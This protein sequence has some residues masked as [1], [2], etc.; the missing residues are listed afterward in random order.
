[1]TKP[2]IQTLLILVDGAFPNNGELPLVLFQQAFDPTTKNL[3][4]TIEKTFHGN[5]WQNSWRNGIFTFH[6]YHSTAH[7]VLGIYSGRVKAQFGGPDGQNVT[8]IAGDVIIVPAGV[9]H[10]N[11]DQSPDFRCVGAYPA[12]QSPDMQYGN[13]GERPQ[14]DQNIKSLALPE[15][16]PVYG[17]SGPLL[18]LWGPALKT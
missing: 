1:M 10:K 4:G 13:P 6:H 14:V 8:A 9:S 11:L 17:K 5:A 7:E 15:F 3:V 16:D 18:E 2:E 12:Q